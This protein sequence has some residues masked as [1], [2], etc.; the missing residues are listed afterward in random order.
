MSVS[1]EEKKG[2]MVSTPGYHLFSTTSLGS[3]EQIS[4]V[5]M[6]A[7]RPLEKGNED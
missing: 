3:V 4:L 1:D 5:W 6:V 7:R 2:F